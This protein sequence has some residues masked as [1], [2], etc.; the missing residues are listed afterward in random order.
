[1]VEEQAFALRRFQEQPFRVAIAADFERPARFDGGK[2]ADEPRLDTVLAGDGASNVFLRC[3]G[4]GG[5]VD[6]PAV[7]G[8]VNPRLNGAS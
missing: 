5:V 6:R 1:M 4:R 8:G 2:D 3:G 7:S